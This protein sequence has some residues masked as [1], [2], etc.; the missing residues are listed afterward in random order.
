MKEASACDRKIEGLALFLC[1]FIRVTIRRS[2][3]CNSDLAVISVQVQETEEVIL[4]LQELGVIGLSR[5]Y[6]DIR[7]V[8][9]IELD[10]YVDLEIKM[11]ITNWH[12]PKLS[13]ESI[14]FAICIRKTH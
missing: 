3:L 7:Y 11:Q 9:V 4:A 5:E 12:N 13:K 2:P 10:C 6:D 1:L 8:L 14:R